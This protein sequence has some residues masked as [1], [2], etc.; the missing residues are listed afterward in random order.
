MY[1]EFLQYGRTNDKTRRFKELYGHVLGII[2]FIG[3]VAGMRHAFD[4]RLFSK[5]L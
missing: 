5:G 3:K 2:Y 4:V 1:Y